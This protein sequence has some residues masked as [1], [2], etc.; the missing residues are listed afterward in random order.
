MYKPVTGRLI[1]QRITTE[2]VTASGIIVQT[3]AGDDDR[4]IVHGTIAEV[5]EDEE[6]YKK[7]E[8]IVFDRYQAVEIDKTD[9]IYS[10]DTGAVY[11]KVNK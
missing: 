8:V 6:D 1:V 3:K 10:V 7:G 2:K 11:A 9:K 4:D 5:T